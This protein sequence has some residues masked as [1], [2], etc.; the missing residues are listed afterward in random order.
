MGHTYAKI[1]IIVY[2]KFSFDWVPCI[3]SGNPKPNITL[4]SLPLPK[5]KK[6]KSLIY[7]EECFD[8]WEST[9]LDDGR[10]IILSIRIKN[11]Y[12]M[13]KSMHVLV[14]IMVT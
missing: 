10:N 7:E 9:G 12:F 8:L 13:K 6:N 1:L 14:K 4:P 11:E 5:I 3:L 2:L